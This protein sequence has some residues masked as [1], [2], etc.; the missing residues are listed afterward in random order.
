MILTAVSFFFGSAVE[1]QICS[2]KSRCAYHGGVYPSGIQGNVAMGAY[3]DR[4][5]NALLGNAMI[6]GMSDGSVRNLNASISA[7]T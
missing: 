5:L 2:G 3:D 4:R 7:T 1:N 6:T